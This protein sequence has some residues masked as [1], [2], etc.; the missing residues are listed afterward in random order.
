MEKNFISTSECLNTN[1]M[2]C[3]QE[4]NHYISACD[5]DRQ[6]KNILSDNVCRRL[7]AARC[8]GDE[9]VRTL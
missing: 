3:Y 4:Y 8:D 7:M 5:G 9:E 2:T 6:G 1:S